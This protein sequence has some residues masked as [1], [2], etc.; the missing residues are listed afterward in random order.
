MRS[1]TSAS[2][3]ESRLAPIHDNKRNRR[4]I[5]SGGRSL[6]TERLFHKFPHKLPGVF[7]GLGPTLRAK[8]GETSPPVLI[9]EQGEN[10]SQLEFRYL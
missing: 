10:G 8:I 1:S 9:T 4:V 6:D 2:R 7:G 5:E 3:C